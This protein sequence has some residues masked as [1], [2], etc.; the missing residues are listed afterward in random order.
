[1]ICP[2]ID[3]PGSGEISDANRFLHAKYMSAAEIYRELCEA[4]YSQIILSKDT[5]RQ[6]CRMFKEGQQMKMVREGG[7]PSVANDDLVKIVE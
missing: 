4:V 7:R 6:L 1:M 3:Y 2:A 5:V